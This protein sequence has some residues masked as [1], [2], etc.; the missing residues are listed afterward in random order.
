MDKALQ[1]VLVFCM[2]FVCCTQRQDANPTH[3]D[4][5]AAKES[6]RLESAP[7]NE[8]GNEA[9]LL[10]RFSSFEE[11]K[12][13]VQIKYNDT[14]ADHSV[15]QVTLIHRS[16]DR[17]VIS[18]LRRGISQADFMHDG[19]GSL[20]GQ[21]KLGLQCPYAFS[22]RKDLELIENLGR[23]RPWVFGKGYVA[24][25][26]LAETMVQHIAEED[27]KN[28]SA[29][30]LAEKGFLNTYNH[31]T[32]QA[33]MTS[34]Y[35]EQLAD[36]VADVHE[37]FNMPALITGSLTTAQL[38]DLILLPQVTTPGKT[39]LLNLSAPSNTKE[40]LVQLMSLPEYQMR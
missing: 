9:L 37:L 10:T 17:E 26:D 38:A 31:I 19:Q 4:S 36:F 6:S 12:A 30:D 8:A 29:D 3:E 15:P 40:V 20:W 34:L 7:V 27:R 2:T 1:F 25:Y 14:I 13:V 11:L 23:R 16:G 18:V 28:L 33:F 24:F 22:H 39:N 5:Q 21:M 32:A 35:D